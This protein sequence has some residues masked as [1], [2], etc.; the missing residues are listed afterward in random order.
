MAQNVLHSTVCELEFHTVK[1]IE[2]KLD[3]T[4]FSLGVF[5]VLSQH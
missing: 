3:I 1:V 5:S 4:C 2:M